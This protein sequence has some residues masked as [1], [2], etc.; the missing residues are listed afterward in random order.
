MKENEIL[1]EMRTRRTEAR[2]NPRRYALLIFRHR[3]PRQFCSLTIRFSL[4]FAESRYDM[5]IFTVMAYGQAEKSRP[6]ARCANALRP[7]IGNTKSDHIYF[8]FNANS[9]KEGSPLNSRD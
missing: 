8:R 9:K 6:F 1:D 4:H 7:N 3:L 5:A 2:I